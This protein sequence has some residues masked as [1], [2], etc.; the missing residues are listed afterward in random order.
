MPPICGTQ[1]ARLIASNRQ[2]TAV[3]RVISYTTPLSLDSVS[4]AVPFQGDLG[5]FPIGGVAVD[6]HGNL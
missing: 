5:L 3:Y 6:A 4:V 1:N 2:L